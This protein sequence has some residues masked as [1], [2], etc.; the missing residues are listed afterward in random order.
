[1]GGQ[2]EV[3]DSTDISHAECRGT[4]EAGAI[5]GRRGP[6]VGR[7]SGVPRG[8]FALERCCTDNSGLND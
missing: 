2:R 1:M 3:A 7:S 4:G 5:H 6:G 8:Y